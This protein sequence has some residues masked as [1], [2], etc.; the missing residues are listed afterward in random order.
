MAVL[1][2]IEL[3]DVVA[4][5]DGVTMVR[6]ERSTGGSGGLFTWPPTPSEG[7]MLV[8]VNEDD[9]I[10]VVAMVVAVPDRAMNS[11]VYLQHV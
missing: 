1:A 6:M 11:V 5:P 3:P 8:I 7:H 2:V 10:A 4:L 9:N